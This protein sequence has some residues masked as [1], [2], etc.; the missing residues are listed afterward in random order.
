M[1][2]RLLIKEITTIA[3]QSIRISETDKILIVG[4]NNSGKS[5]FLREISQR[6]L[7][8]GLTNVIVQDVAFEKFGTTADLISFLTENGEFRNDSYVYKNWQVPRYLAEQWGNE[9]IPSHIGHG[10]LK[11]INASERLT[12]CQEQQSIAFDEQKSRPQHILY[13]DAAMMNHI[14][15]LFK[16]AFGKGLLINFKGG[17]RIPFHVGNLPTFE[18]PPDRV[19]DEYVA[20]VTSNPKLETQGDGVK[21]YAGILFEALVNKLD[22]TII[23]EPEAF[24]HPPQMRKL[25]ETLSSEVDG[26]LLVATHSGDILKGFL[27]GTKGQ[28]RVLRIHRE[29]DRPIIYEAAPEV[30][31]ELWRRP[32]MRYSNA[33]EGLFHEETILCED[34]SD[35]R[36]INAV[37]DHV[38]STSN[39]SWKDTVYIPTG[40]KHL[41]PKIGSLLNKIGVPTKALFDID[42]LAERTLVKD[43]IEAFG[44]IWEDFLHDWERLDSAVR[45]GNKSK[46]APQ[47]KESILQIIQASEPEDLPKSAI[48]EALKQGKEWN[49]IKKYGESALP[50]GEDFVVYRRLKSNLE[51]IGIYLIHVGEIENFHKE[52]S[53]HGPRFVNGLLASVPLDKP[54]LSD[55]RML[56]SNIHNGNHSK[57]P[58]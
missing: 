7:A 8:H 50:G 9:G 25:G 34:D 44:G 42:F 32:E 56:V 5:Q 18:T 13:D 1:K 52:T 35:C 21:S 54:E 15:S 45:K 19:G 36:L 57:L 20:A 23:D 17:S 49:I 10:F 16:R 58:G 24:L 55:L 2:P 38:R 51:A 48:S 30:I 3:N 46:T 43:A 40:G 4:A 47:I 29:L 28:V 27:E 14:S 53:G 12:I 11:L 39:T 41:I 33:L 37:A 22:I 31:K 6:A 26:Q